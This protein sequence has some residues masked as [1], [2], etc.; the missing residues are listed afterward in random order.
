MPEQVC[1]LPTQTQSPLPLQAWFA[2]QALLQ[3]TLP[4]HT[5]VLHCWL[6]MQVDPAGSCGMQRL[7]AQYSPARQSVDVV[8]LGRQALFW[9]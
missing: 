2:P 3:H 6:V 9:Q 1:V 5:D 8:Q 7:A 4:E